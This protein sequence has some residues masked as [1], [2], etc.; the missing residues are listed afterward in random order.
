M[1]FLYTIRHA[2]CETAI[3]V[4]FKAGLSATVTLV[5]VPKAYGNKA[6]NRS[7][8]FSWCSRLRDGRE[9]I[10]DESGDRPK[11]TR[12]EVK[13]VVVADLVKNDR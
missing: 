10:E 2:W 7:N 4:C 1:S 13:N 12:T 9:L 5:I 3:K 11:S 6:L 8:L